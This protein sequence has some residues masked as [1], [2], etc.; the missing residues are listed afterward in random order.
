MDTDRVQCLIGTGKREGKKEKEQ[1]KNERFD[2]ADHKQA[3][4]TRN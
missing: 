2:D 4:K 1:E 3:T